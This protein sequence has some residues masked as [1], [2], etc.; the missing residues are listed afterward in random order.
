M[1]K[2]K[3]LIVTLD[4]LNDKVHFSGQTDGQPS[5][6]IDYTS[7][8]GDNLGYTSLELLLLSLGSCMASA[9]LLFLR[10]K[11][12]AITSLNVRIEAE[13]RS[14]HPTI[15]TSINLMFSFISPD[16]SVADFE[17]VLRMAEEKFCP[18]YAMISGN[19]KITTTCHI[20]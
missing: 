16:L 11:G 14:G 2:S 10:R 1:D 6:S 20:G 9:V 15:L 4:L 3:N 17:E 13:R 8:L 12:K 7:P 18:V 5:I 19:T